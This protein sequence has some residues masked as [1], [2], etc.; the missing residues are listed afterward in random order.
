MQATDK[1]DLKALCKE[2]GVTIPPKKAVKIK[3]KNTSCQ[4]NDVQKHWEYI[5]QTKVIK[6]KKELG[7]FL[8]GKEQPEMLHRKVKVYPDKRALAKEA[9][10]L[11]Y[12]RPIVIKRAPTKKSENGLD[13]SEED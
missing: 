6:N 13:I 11:N 12:K 8:K 5:K 2:H 3:R 10:A 1:H 9:A 4:T 7:R